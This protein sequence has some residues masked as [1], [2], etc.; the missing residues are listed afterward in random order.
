VIVTPFSEV[1]SPDAFTI[2]LPVAVTDIADDNA[3]EPPDAVI[4]TSP[5]LA[6]TDELATV[7]DVPAMNVTPV[8]ADTGEPPTTVIEPPAMNVT[9]PAVAVT[10]E[11][12][13]T[14]INPPAANET[15]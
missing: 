13:P 8:P 3:T 12:D 9:L 6:L 1:T 14:V 4:D 10:G 5:A 2:T 11:D 7:I 15:F